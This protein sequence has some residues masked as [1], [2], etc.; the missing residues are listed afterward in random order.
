VSGEGSPQVERADLRAL[1]ELEIA[2]E[3]TGSLWLALASPTLP[4]EVKGF[5]RQFAV[6]RRL[7]LEEAGQ[8]DAA[9]YY[10]LILMTSGGAQT[11]AE[12]W[13]ARETSKVARLPGRAAIALDNTRRSPEG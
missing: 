8:Y 13:S 6:E 7:R 3:Q 12:G 4:S 10:S 11:E 1:S 5:I 9:G 2:K